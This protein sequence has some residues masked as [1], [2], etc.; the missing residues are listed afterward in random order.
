MKNAPLGIVVVADPEVTDV[1]VEDSS[2]IATV[3]H[4]LQSLGLGSCWLQVRER[5]SEDGKSRR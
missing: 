4:L 1:W 3:I 2:I 5:L